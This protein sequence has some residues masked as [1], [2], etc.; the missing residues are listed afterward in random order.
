MINFWK[1]KKVF[2][3]GIDG[4][5][6]S[7]LAKELISKKA[8][9]YGLVKR[10]KKSL[11]YFENIN[12][13]ITIY[14]GD[15]KNKN[16]LNKILKSNKIEICFHLA[17][18]VEVGKANNNP[19]S[20]FETN[21]R[22]TYTL[23]DTINKN[24]KFIKSVIIASSDKVYGTYPKK[25]LPYKEDYKL[26]ANYPYEVSKA[27]CDI[28]SKSFS[29]DLFRLPIIITRFTNI[30]G[31]GQLNFSALIPDIIQTILLKKKFIPRGDGSA[32]RDF[33]YVK[34]IISIYLLLSKKL[35]LSKK[36]SGEIF[37]AGTN[38]PI[39]VKQIIEKIL[40]QNNKKKELKEII[41]LMKSKSA[42]GE[43]PYQ[44]MD[45]K[46]INKYFR[47]KPTYTFD[48]GIRETINWY[49]KFIVN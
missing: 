12:K 9:V 22:G 7:N 35:Y 46:K 36:Y 40:I 13:K 33:I 23:L 3:T 16:L 45:C 6:G 5:V 27:C 43:I 2:I 34:D 17:A 48:R 18:Q 29:G 32:I 31:P 41:K 1:N 11:L 44:Y 49:K 24:N 15:I 30:Y 8:K 28:I 38:K 47:W 10:R 19:F 37:N 20:T 4:F 21:I 26:K 42:P 39:S 25:Y 14:K